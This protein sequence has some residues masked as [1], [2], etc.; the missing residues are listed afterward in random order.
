[1]NQNAYNKGKSIPAI[2]HVYEKILLHDVI[3]PVQKLLLHADALAHVPHKFPH[4]LYFCFWDSPFRVAGIER[5]EFD[6]IRA[7]K[8]H[9]SERAVVVR[10]DEGEVVRMH[11]EAAGED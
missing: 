11:F 1:M 4:M 7:V 10:H 9:F 3:Y 5:R 8:L 6:D 2:E